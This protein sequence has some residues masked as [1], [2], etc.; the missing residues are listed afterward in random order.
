MDRC[1]LF[2]GDAIEL[3]RP[4]AFSHPRRETTA[5][6]RIFNAEVKSQLSIPSRIP[7]NLLPIRTTLTTIFGKN[8]SFKS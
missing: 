2:S 6:F 7:S 1:L 8:F 4:M 3:S 5:R